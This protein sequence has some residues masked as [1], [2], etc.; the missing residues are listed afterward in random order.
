[1]RARSAKRQRRGEKRGAPNRDRCR[2]RV[3]ATICR[4]ETTR[5]PGHAR[6]IAFLTA[7]LAI[8]KNVFADILPLS[9]ELRLSPAVSTA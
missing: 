1:M 9:A 5:L 4:F 2:R 8:S 6:Y 7:E 3:G